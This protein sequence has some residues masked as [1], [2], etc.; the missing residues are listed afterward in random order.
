ME[1]TLKQIIESYNLIMNNPPYHFDRGKG[2]CTGCEGL[3][4]N[5]DELKL[6]C[7]IYKQLMKYE[8]GE[9]MKL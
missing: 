8:K 3:L 5:I 9:Q 1:E 7:E 4:Y 6:Q 2:T